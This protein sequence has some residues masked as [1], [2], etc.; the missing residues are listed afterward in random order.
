MRSETQ[1]KRN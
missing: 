1:M